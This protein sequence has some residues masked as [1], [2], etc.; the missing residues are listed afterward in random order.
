MKTPSSITT[1]LALPTM[2]FLGPNIHAISAAVTNETETHMTV[3]YHQNVS[4]LDVLQLQC[5]QDGAMLE[6]ANYLRPMCKIEEP[7]VNTC[8][9]NTGSQ[10]DLAYD[11]AV[12][13]YFR[14]TADSDFLDIYNCDDGD[15]FGPEGGDSDNVTTSTSK[16]KHY[17]GLRDYQLRCGMHV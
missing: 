14:P 12:G 8:L 1:L 2:L 17:P 13:P 4:G 7:I 11:P 5:P 9:W 16:K 6:G 10:E 15:I 3:T